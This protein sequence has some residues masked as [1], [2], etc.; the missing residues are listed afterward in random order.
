[1]E[2]RIQEWLDSHQPTT[3]IERELV[4]RAARLSWT[5]DRAERHETA[6]LA[7]RVRTAMLR[8]RAKR[9][10]KVCELGRKLFYNAGKRLLPGSGPAWTDDPSAFVARLEESPEGAQWLLDR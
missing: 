7:R 1:L 9:I 6:L 2:A 10:E 8:S 4:T 3:A 5:L